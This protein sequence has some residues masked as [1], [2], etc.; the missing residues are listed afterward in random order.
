[1]AYLLLPPLFPSLVGSDR[2]AP[3]PP[4]LCKTFSS[5]LLALFSLPFLN[6]NFFIPYLLFKSWAFGLVFFSD[7]SASI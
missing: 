1:M 4:V 3:F 7:P 6:F 5:L 2:V